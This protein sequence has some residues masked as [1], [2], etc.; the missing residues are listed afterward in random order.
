MPE[1]VV[2][3]NALWCS[4]CNVS[5]DETNQL[6]TL[7]RPVRARTRAEER[8][9]A[10]GCDGAISRDGTIRAM[11]LY[12]DVPGANTGLGSTVGIGWQAMDYHG[13]K[14]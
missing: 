2:A 9:G 11:Q 6:E 13:P 12:F 8:L 5:Q 4:L 1:H 10:I 7:L 14:W 3:V